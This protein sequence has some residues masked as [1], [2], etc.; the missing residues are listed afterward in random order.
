[1]TAANLSDP[2]VRE[3][4]RAKV[5]GAAEFVADRR[6]GPMLHAAYLR[7][8]HPHARISAID[9]TG[10]LEVPGVRNVLVGADV[11][12]A[13]LGRHIQDWPV[14]AWDRVRMVGDRV[15]V[16]AAES[17]E[18]AQAGCRR[19]S[20][21]YEVLPA[22]FDPASAL[23]PDAPVL[24]PAIRECHSF[25][26]EGLDTPQPNVQG[27]VVHEHGDVDQVLRSAPHVFEHE[28]RIPRTFAGYLEPRATLVWIG[29]DGRCHVATSS[30]APFKL[31]QQLALGLNVPEGNLVVES[32]VIGGDFGGKGLSIDEYVLVLLAQ[33]TGSSVMLITPYE[34]ELAATNT[35]HAAQIRLR[36]GVDDDGRI[37]AHEGRVWLDGGAYAAGKSNSRRIP[38]AARYT[39]AGYAV[40]NARVEALSVYTNNVPG[41]QVRTPGQ[42]QNAFAAESHMDLIA[43]G[44]G[45]DPLEI[46]VR[47]AL[48]PGDLDVS[49]VRWDQPMVLPVLEELRAGMRTRPDRPGR[50][51]G[52]GIS[53]R[54]AKPGSASVLLEVTRDASVVVR[55]GV[56]DQ[57]GG[58]HTMLRRVVA[59]T[60]GLP[61]DRVRVSQGTTD[62]DPFDHGVGGSRVT[63]MVGGAAEA[64]AKALAPRLERCCP[65]GTVIEQLEAA[66]HRGGIEQEGT[67]E[68]STGALAANAYAIDVEVDF[69]TGAVEITDC[70]CVADV[71]TIINPL[72]A[73][74]Q[75]MGGL[76]S[77]LG[78]ALLEELR[79][80]E[81]AVVARD[82]REYRMPCI[83]DVPGV[84]LRV[85]T[86]G[87]G[88]GPFGAKGVGELTNSAIV[89]AI[90]NAVADAIGT[91]VTSLPL[92]PERVLAALATAVGRPRL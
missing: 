32:T 1:M 87:K 64:G 23:E 66:A 59:V 34:D 4:A 70:L 77:G 24:H 11:S 3:E 31:R 84:R 57:G 16:V 22:I 71:G 55:T 69:E 30:K 81:G 36:T 33:R 90:A 73:R 2:E 52:I 19:I 50:G 47:N 6:V 89:G 9:V 54:P 88:F 27:R 49:G 63:P 20:V 85:L 40:P 38:P 13:R 72:A 44:L 62:R 29:N 53:V 21:D 51:R 48:R 80:D 83:A 39:L 10:A 82:L 26:D 65:G 76:V 67:F 15:A 14:L 17:I 12:P 5:T 91:H 37:L 28:F 35:R 58:A 68:E 92:H 46:R 7:S 79:I 61:E 86:Q 75:L 18:A 56:P 74:G 60:L 41:G 42:P 45:I 8:P 78:Q 43:R 25:G